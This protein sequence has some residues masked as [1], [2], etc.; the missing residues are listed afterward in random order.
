LM[1]GAKKVYSI[2]SE[3]M[4]KS[5]FP[6]YAAMIGRTEFERVITSSV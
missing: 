5:A 2:W 3:G 6:E 1:G 4:W